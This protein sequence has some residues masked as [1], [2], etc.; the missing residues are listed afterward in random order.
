MGYTIAEQ[1][2]DYNDAVMTLT[3]GRMELMF[4]AAVLGPCN[5]RI[6]CERP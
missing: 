2:S 1:L 3:T 5:L 4:V 6:L